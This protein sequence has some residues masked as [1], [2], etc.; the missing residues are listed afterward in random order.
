MAERRELS[1]ADL[2]EAV[3][4]VDRL[5]AG[6]VTVGRWSL[7]QICNHLGTAFRLQL[8]GNPGPT[9]VRRAREALRVRFFRMGRF[10]DGVEVPLPALLPGPGLDDL[11]EA[12]ALREAIARFLSAPGPFP[13]H[14][15]LG[16]LT[17]DEWTRFHGMHAA[18]HLGFALPRTSPDGDDSQPGTVRNEPA[19]PKEAGP[20]S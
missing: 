16:P 10:P 15:V 13:P 8:D 1:F 17:R 18:H 12:D 19:P 11:A 3:A 5:L 14:P 4:E 2:G 9:P 6:Y 7:G 20:A